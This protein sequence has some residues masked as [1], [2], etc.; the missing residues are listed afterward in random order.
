[1]KNRVILKKLPEVIVYFK[2]LKIENYQKYFEYIPKIGKEIEKINP[3]LKA[4]EPNYCFSIYLDDE[5]K[6]EN[7]KIEFCEAVK[8]FG[9]ETKDIKFKKIKE[10]NKAACIY[11]KGSYETIGES[12][13]YLNKW[14][15]DQGYK[16]ID[17]TRESY[18]D[19]IWNKENKSQW[20]TEIQIP[21][22]E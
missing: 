22:T 21:I 7:F 9:N 18:I 3:D 19:G 11:H 17:K 15:K 1:M 10:V 4:M 20:L 14:I 2:K 12:Y 6:S 8:N 16:I 13:A 5:F